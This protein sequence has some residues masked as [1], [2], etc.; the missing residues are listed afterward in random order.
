VVQTAWTVTSSV[1]GGPGVVAIDF[2]IIGGTRKLISANT[3]VGTIFESFMLNFVPF[4]YFPR[5]GLHVG[6]SSIKKCFDKGC[7]IENVPKLNAKFATKS[8]SVSPETGVESPVW[9]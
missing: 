9:Q 5:C 6:I 7:V 1:S 3:Q 4:E 8:E 2:E